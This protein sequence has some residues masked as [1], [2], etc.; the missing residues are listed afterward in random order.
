MKIKFLG[1]KSRNK[2][3][4][5]LIESPSRTKILLDCGSPPSNKDL[6]ILPNELIPEI[7]AIV[8]THAHLDHWGYLPLMI[9]RNYRGPIIMTPATLELLKNFAIKDY[10]RY[11]DENSKLDFKR[12]FNTLESQINTINYGKPFNIDDLNMYL[13]PAN[14]ILGSAQILVESTENYEQILYTGDFNPGNNYLFDSISI[15]RINERYSL[16]INPNVVIIECS[17]VGLDKNQYISE[18]ELFMKNMNETFRKLGNILIPAKALGDAQDFILKIIHFCLNKELN[19]PAEIFT[20][21]SLEEVNKVY[22]KYRED[23]KNPQLVDLFKTNMIIKDFNQFIRNNYANYEDIFFN[24]KRDYGLKLFIATGGNL[25]VGSSK[26]VFN[27]LK[28]GKN[29]LIIIPHYLK[30]P[31]CNAKV[32]KLKTLSLHGNFEAVL[33][34][35]KE[36]DILK[37]SRFLISHGSINNKKFLHNSLMNL[38][39]VSQIPNVGEI[40]NS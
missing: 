35:I 3:A 18:E 8:L 25:D 32:L 24:N 7:K 40:Y 16:E 5:Y 34:Y 30:T 6:K 15:K 33:N 4:S 27:Y 38:K 23:F 36:L 17:N 1:D 39:I 26:K 37:K 12:I 21:G 22:Y 31:N 2:I 10:F 28:N 29:N 20:L 19:M 9:K 11:I 13:L 14:H